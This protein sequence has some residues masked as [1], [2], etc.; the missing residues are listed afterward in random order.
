MIGTRLFIPA[1]LLLP[2]NGAP[3]RPASDH[4]SLVIIMGYYVAPDWIADRSNLFT[5]LSG[6]LPAVGTAIFGIRVQGDF[7]G[8]AVRS[9]STAIR[10]EEIASQI[11]GP[12]DVSRA[13]DLFEQAARAML[14]DLGEWRLAHAQREAVLPS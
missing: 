13:A 14:A 1:L 9:Q 8:T 12:I 7:T 6:G 10:L 5:F 11:N 3:Q 4:G 2:Q